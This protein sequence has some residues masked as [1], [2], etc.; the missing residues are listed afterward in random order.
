MDTLVFC[1]MVTAAL[2]VFF[3]DKNLSIKYAAVCYALSYSA[4]F[5][6]SELVQDGGR[7]FALNAYYLNWLIYDAFTVFAIFA[8]H[9]MTKERHASEVKLAYLMSIV[10]MSAYLTMHFLAFVYRHQT[11]WFYDF[12]TVIVNTTAVLISTN[13]ILSWSNIKV[14]QCISSYR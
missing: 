7:Y 8:V 5:F 14:R 1:L 4:S 6:M 2:W 12:Y 9:T 13:F 3:K 11:H 10:N